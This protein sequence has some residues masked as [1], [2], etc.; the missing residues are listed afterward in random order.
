MGVERELGF[1]KQPPCQSKVSTA[2]R[3][4]DA[5]RDTG[6]SCSAIFSVVTPLLQLQLKKMSML[7]AGLQLE[8]WCPQ[9]PL[10]RPSLDRGSD[11]QPGDFLST[12]SMP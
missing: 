12:F 6:G 8:G 1:G 4:P 10:Q 9:R 3:H 2:Q 7:L 5:Q 11:L